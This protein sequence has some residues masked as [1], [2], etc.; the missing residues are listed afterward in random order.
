MQKFSPKFRTLKDVD[1]FL[2][3][4]CP[5][6][7]K[8]LFTNNVLLRLHFAGVPFDIINLLSAWGPWSAPSAC[9]RT[10]G[11]GRQRRKRNCNGPGECVGVD[12]MEE[13]CNKGPCRG[14]RTGSQ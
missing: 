11:E 2:H 7:H 8:F 10:C 12:F 9:S 14:G 5:C 6:Y 1:Y 4:I 3:A 13:A